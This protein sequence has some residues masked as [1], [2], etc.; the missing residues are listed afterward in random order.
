MCGSGSRAGDDRPRRRISTRVQGLP[1]PARGRVRVDPRRA[2]PGPGEA[3]GSAQRPHAGRRGSSRAARSTCCLAIA[4]QV[5][6]TIEHAKLYA[7]RAAAGRRA[8]GAGE[9]LGGGVGVAVPRGVARGDRE[10]DDGRGRAT[11]AALVLEDGNIAWPEGRP[12]STR[13]ACR[14]DGSAG[15][16]GSSCAI[17]TRRSAAKIARSWRRSHTTPRWRSSTAAR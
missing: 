10:D 13:P 4:A 15:R 11:G 2:H 9:D 12:G 1:E 6:Q 3:C 17:A 7:K 8:R 16:S 14:C 5:A